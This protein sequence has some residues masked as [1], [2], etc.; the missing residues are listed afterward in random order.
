[1]LKTDKVIV[2][3]GKYDAIR[4]ANIVDAAI[5]R[6]EGF[7]VF[8]DKEKQELLRTL[9]QRGLLVL[10]DGDSAGMLI[11]NHIRGPCR[12]N[13]SRTSTSRTCT[14]RR[15]EAKPSKESRRGRHSRRHPHRALKKAGVTEGDVPSDPRNERLITRMDFLPGHLAGGRTAK[16]SG[17]PQEAGAAGTMTGKQLLRIVNMMV[18]YDEYKA[19]STDRRWPDDTTEYRV[20]GSVSEALDRLESAGKAFVVGGCT[21]DHC[22][23]MCPMTGT[24]HLGTAG[25]DVLCSRTAGPSRPPAH[26]TVA[27]LLDDMPSNGDLPGRRDHEFRHPDSVSFTRSIEEDLARRDFT[28][29]AIAY[30]PTR[31]MASTAVPPASEPLIRFVGDPRPASGRRSASPRCASETSW[32]SIEEHT[33]AA[34]HKLKDRILHVA[35]GGYHRTPAA[36]LRERGVPG[37]ADF[38][39]VFAIS[40]RNWSPA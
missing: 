31:G 18:S 7:R 32:A 19:S 9:A 5:L 36:P 29:N 33:S 6:T 15:S 35:S 14:A 20:A 17:S 10:T 2:V 3:E 4:I 21:R 1:M 16:R 13:R 23:A 26:S 37:P 40:S 12:R 27:A 22:S 28:M 30:S 24:S 8:K 25:G 39:D 34:I 38:R 11:R